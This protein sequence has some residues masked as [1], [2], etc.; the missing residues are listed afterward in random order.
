MALSRLRPISLCSEWT[1]IARR[2]PS[3]GLARPSEQAV[4]HARPVPAQREQGLSWHR[5]SL[6]K[7]AVVGSTGQRNGSFQGISRGLEAKR[8]P[9]PCIEPKGD[10]IKVMLSVNG[11]VR[12]VR[13]VLAQQTIGVLVA[14]ALPGAFRITEVDA[15]IR[16]DGELAMISQFRSPIPSQRRHHHL[17]QVLHPGDQCADDAVAVFSAD[18]DQHYKARAAFDERGDVAISG[19]TQQIAFPVAGYRSIL[20]LSWSVA[21]RHG[22]DDL[23]SRL[24]RR[25]R[26]P[27]PAHDP[28][29]A[30]MGQQFLLERATRLNEQ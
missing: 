13:E 7:Y 15:D 10:L 14:A 4:D 23:P 21:D 5:D 20:D 26:C 16:R 29:A 24:A 22:I 6:A 8:F 18:L 11:S 19:T 9:W 30:Q 2:D 27:A 28:A 17:R 25:C 3:D 12:A 1:N